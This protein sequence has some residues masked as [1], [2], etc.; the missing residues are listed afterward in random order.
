[1]QV[2]IV[3]SGNVAH[4][5]G[6]KIKHA[7]HTVS[8]VLSRSVRNTLAKELG[9]EAIT[10]V[11]QLSTSAHLYLLAVSDSAVASVAAHLLWIGGIVAHTAGALPLQAVASANKHGVLYPLQS[12]RKEKDDYGTIPLLVDGNGSEVKQAL[13][14]FA[15]SISTQV[16]VADDAYRLKL[17]TAAVVVSNFTNHLYALAENFCHKEGAD[18]HLLQPLIEEVALRM[19]QFSPA[20]MQTGPAVRGDEATIYRHLQVLE[21]YPHLQ[22][23]YQVLTQSIQLKDER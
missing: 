2:V 15:Q 17:H 13:L 4:V 8:Q 1:M 20:Q 7:G 18:F 6:R 14:D 3:G 10:G 22:K 19:R 5:L 9:A 21:S 11:E 12:L 23:I 16:A